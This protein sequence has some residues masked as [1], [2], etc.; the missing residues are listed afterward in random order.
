MGSKNKTTKKKN[1]KFDT[2]RQTLFVKWHQEGGLA[3]AETVAR[4]LLWL[5]LDTPPEEFSEKEWDVRDEEH[6]AR[7]NASSASQVETGVTF[8]QGKK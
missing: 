1:E 6:Q 5:L 4:F 2:T 8:G 3:S 7:W